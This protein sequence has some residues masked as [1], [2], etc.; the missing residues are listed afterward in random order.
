MKRAM[1]W[2]LVLALLLTAAGC[3]GSAGGSDS[4]RVPAY[5]DEGGILTFA[6]TPPSTRQ[7]DIEQYFDAGFN[8]YILTEDRVSLTDEEG[9][10]TDAY[11]QAIA[12]ASRYGN[13]L[14]RNQYNAAEYWQ[15]TTGIAYNANGFTLT[16]VPVPKRSITDQLNGLGKVVGYYQF[17]EPSLESLDRLAGLADWQNANAAGQL[18]YANLFPSYA[19]KKLIG[20]DYEAYLQK[21]VDVLLSRLSTP[22]GLSIDNYPLMSGTSG[23]MLRASYLSDLLIAAGVVKKYNDT[24]GIPSRITL[25]FCI[26]N[27][28]DNALRYPTSARDIDFQINTC[29][30]MGAKTLEFFLYRTVLNM[31]GMVENGVNDKLAAFDYVKE[32]TGRLDRWD[33]VIAAFDWEGLYVVDGSEHNE[34]AT[35]LQMVRSR[36]LESPAGVAAVSARTDTVIGQFSDKDGY[37]GYMVVNYTEPSAGR[38]DVVELTFADTQRVVVWQ[39]GEEQVYDLEDHRL[40][41]DLTAGGG[42][43]VV[44]CR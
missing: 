15:N 34:N 40:T 44:A 16:E 33:H 2:L 20:G 43:F 42:A 39:E 36:T 23:N 13:V 12:A 35:A 5:P 25:G 9:V 3:G 4:I 1:A 28:S 21:Y 26:Q 29:L 17:D 37:R 30:A 27:F 32:A 19:D 7:E 22:K 6:D 10:L 41:L 11:K 38:I 8:T 18:F 24:P 14:L 31:V